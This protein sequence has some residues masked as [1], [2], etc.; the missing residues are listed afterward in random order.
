MSGWLDLLWIVFL[1]VVGWAMCSAAPKENQPILWTIYFGI[2]AFFVILTIVMSA[3]QRKK[4]KK[5]AQQRIA[6]IAAASSPA[7]TS[8]R[9]AV[10]PD[11]ARTAASAASPA[12]AAAASAAPAQPSGPVVDI[13]HDIVTFQ[14]DGTDL[15]NPDGTQRQQVLRS[16][17][18]RR[19]PFED[20]DEATLTFYA[21]RQEG[22][23]IVQVEADGDVIGI[24]PQEYA[25]DLVY[26]ADND[27]YTIIKVTVTGGRTRPDG[28]RAPYGMRLSVRI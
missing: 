10:S 24:V 27:E 19:E 13:E 3:V 28:T 16:L 5:K 23:N 8:A 20:W 22:R 2:I 7:A 18:Y 9:P 15:C 21:T 6:R 17:R 1:L 26:A 14:L 4:K 12:P 25:D 11:P